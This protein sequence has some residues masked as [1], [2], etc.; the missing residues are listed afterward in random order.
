MAFT[1]VTLTGTIDVIK[2]GFTKFNDLIDD[3]LDTANGL[4]ASQIGIEDSAENMAAANVEAAL[5]EIYTDTSSARTLADGLDENSATTTGLTWGYK[6]GTV[7][8]DNIVSTVS[9]GTVGLTDDS[10]NYIE[11][12]SGGTV[13]KSTTGFTSGKIPIRQVTCASGVQT[14]STD[15]RSWFNTFTNINLGYVSRSNFIWKD[16]DEIYIGSGVYHHSGTT[17]QM[18]Y[19]NSILTFQLGS[20]GSNSASDDLGNNE[21]HYIYIDD[22]AV[23]TAGTNVLTASEF[24]NDTTAPTYSYTKHGWYN[25][26]DRCIFAIL[27]SA[28]AQIVE[29]FHDGGN[30]VRHSPFRTC[31]TTSKTDYDFIAEDIDT[32][33]TDMYLPIPG[34]SIKAN[35]LFAGIY[36]DGNSVMY[37]RTNGATDGNGNYI[38]TVRSDDAFGYRQVLVF[39]DSSGI[40]EVKYDASNAN[41]I[42]GS[43]TEWYFPVGI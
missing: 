33:F 30:C 3:L 38:M 28:S 29:F 18:V 35:V 6:A 37:W 7:R 43:V 17:D 21:W 41:T 22:S 23:V 1:K 34:F 20:A 2:E 32:T 10:E 26:N 25:G 13:T 4:G 12:S 40:I 19:W 11:I 9:A 36:S 42:T 5:A 39:T 16:T 15:K 27:T 14:V 24:L 8:F 31:G